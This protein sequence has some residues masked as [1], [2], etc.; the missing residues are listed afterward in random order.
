MLR[1]NVYS[2][3]DL[4]CV[5]HKL[6]NILILKYALCSKATMDVPESK[7]IDFLIIKLI[8]GPRNIEN[9]VLHAVDELAVLLII[10]FRLWAVVF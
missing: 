10:I 6:T 5:W 7:K 3:T 8:K 4:Q 9:T 2:K 1:K